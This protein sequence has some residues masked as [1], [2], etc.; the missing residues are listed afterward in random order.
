M[1]MKYE[2]SIS[3]GFGEP[4]VWIVCTPNGITDAI[5]KAYRKYC[6]DN[7]NWDPMIEITCR[8]VKE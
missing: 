5:N 3:N 4:F 1:A 2:V 7:E 6:D 8:R